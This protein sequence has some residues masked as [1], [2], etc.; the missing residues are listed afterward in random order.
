MAR[1]AFRIK[2]YKHPRLKFVVRSKLSGRWKRRFFHTKA[3]AQTYVQLKETELLNQGKEGAMF[4]SSLRVMAQRE[5][6]RLK[7]FGK[8]ISDAADF[9]IKHLETVASSVP[10]EQLRK[11]LIH[12]RTLAKRDPG[13]IY[14]IGNRTKRFCAAFPGRSA[15]EFTTSEIDTWL[16]SLNVAA[17]TRNTYRRDMRTLFSFGVIRKYCPH[18]PV[19]ETTKAKADDDEVGILSVTQVTTLL[20]T[21][22]AD[23]LPFWAI[24][25]FAGLRRSEI[26][27]LDWADID[28]E[29]KTVH[30]H[31]RQRKTER[32]RRFVDMQPNLIAWLA[33]HRQITGRVTPTNLRKHF[34]AHREAAGLLDN[35]P[36]NA[37]RHS[38]GSYHL[39]KFKNARALALQMG[40][41]ED[42]I[43]KHYRQLVKPN[44]ADC[45]WK[46]RPPGK[47]GKKV[48]AFAAAA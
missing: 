39:A 48:I 28:F 2:P 23:M 35:W 21:A 6:D 7:T 9:Y 36:D 13:Y 12:N 11:E 44:E 42:V 29:A 32:S 40:N 19:I 26:E 1:A 14:D 22:P 3:E 10:I 20:S 8:S 47:D 30:V 24:G 46:I 16:E 5:S 27:R 4:P 15:A 17:G 25:C 18:N 33:P 38:F 45:Y 43:F 37:C 31:G 34:D 41:S